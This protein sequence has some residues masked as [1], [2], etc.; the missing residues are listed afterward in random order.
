MSNQNVDN[1]INYKNSKFPE[2]ISSANTPELSEENTKKKWL[3]NNIQRLMI[4]V[5]LIWF[6]LVIIYISQFFGW[7]NLFL[8]MPDEFGGFIAGVTLPLAIIWLVIAYIDRG[9]SFKNEAKLLR[10]YMNSL[11]YPEEG[12]AETAKAMA[13]AIRS[14]IIELQEV[15]KLATEQTEKIKNELSDRV[16]DFAT[17]VKVLDNYSSKTISELT[18]GVKTLVNNFDYVAEKAITSTET[19]QSKIHEFTGSG[20]Q[21]RSSVDNIFEM[22]LPRIQELKASSSLIKNINDE[23]YSKMLQANDMLVDFQSRITQNLTAVSETINAQTERLDEISE[24]SLTNAANFKNVI[25]NDIKIIEDNLNKHS[26]FTN[27]FVE[28]LDNN[29]NNLS[30]KFS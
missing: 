19:L 5:S 13:D 20:E 12:S 17:L 18:D 28:K 7:S 29:I 9:A 23:N 16:D 27:E 21:I 30:R 6:G 2:F 8:M 1:N 11:I 24:K 25:S 10:S 3:D 14:Q 4:W 15:T 22:L 26:S